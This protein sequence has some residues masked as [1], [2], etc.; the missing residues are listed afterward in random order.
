[1]SL[2]RLARLALLSQ[3]QQQASACLALQH[4]LPAAAGAQQRLYQAA[5]VPQPAADGANA[6]DQPGSEQQYRRAAG[7]RPQEQAWAPQ[8]SLPPASHY[9]V[10]VTVKAHDLKFLK[11]ASTVIRDLMLV[12]FAPKGQTAVP[13]EWRKSKTGVPYVQ[14]V[15]EVIPG[16]QNGNTSSSSSSSS[17]RH[18]AVLLL[19]LSS[20]QQQHSGVFDNRQGVLNTH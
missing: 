2:A 20:G 13:P 1:M 18:L 8:R 10:K 6:D 5:A 15:S 17:G 19:S 11:L 7:S 16:A 14:L 9:S 3:Q 12:H 4:L